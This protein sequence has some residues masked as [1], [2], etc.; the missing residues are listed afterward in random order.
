MLYIVSKRFA[1]DNMVSQLVDHA[2]VRVLSGMNIED[3]LVKNRQHWAD[4][5]QM[6]AKIRASKVGGGAA[7]KPGTEQMP[8]YGG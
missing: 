7:I 8:N 2:F 3:E 5:V 4:F 1:T 6:L